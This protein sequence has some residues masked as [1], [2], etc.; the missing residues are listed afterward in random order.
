MDHRFGKKKIARN[1]NEKAWSAQEKKD[2]CLV[3]SQHAACSGG[4]DFQSSSGALRYLEIVF[5][6][7]QAAKEYFWFAFYSQHKKITT[8]LQK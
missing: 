7:L 1:G 4:E 3:A 8:S 6:F 2:E 5:Y